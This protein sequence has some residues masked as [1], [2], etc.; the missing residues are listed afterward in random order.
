ML[1]VARDQHESVH[2]AIWKYAVASNLS[3]CK[4]ENSRTVDESKSQVRAEAA[5]VGPLRG[6]STS[7][8][9]LLISR[10]SSGD[11]CH[12]HGNLHGNSQ[13]DISIWVG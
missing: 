12:H 13:L 9:G 8:L 5:A 7:C 6:F 1:L 4:R 11:S 2:A 3:M 10:E